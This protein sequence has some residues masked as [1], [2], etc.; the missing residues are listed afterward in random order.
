MPPT[1]STPPADPASVRDQ[2]YRW[3]ELVRMVLS[4]RRE[5]I[6][7]NIVAVLGALAAVP[8]PLLIP[9]LVD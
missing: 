4:H 1:A 5:L 6:A 9:L 3:R 2:P 8:V 7:A